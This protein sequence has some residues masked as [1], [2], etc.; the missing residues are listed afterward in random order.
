MFN[1]GKTERRMNEEEQNQKQTKASFFSF[2]AFLY[3]QYTN[4]ARAL[5]LAELNTN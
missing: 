5:A 4:I 3:V 1:K 2:L